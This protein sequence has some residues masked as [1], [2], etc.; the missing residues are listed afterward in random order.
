MIAAIACLRKSCGNAFFNVAAGENLLEDFLNRKHSIVTRMAVMKNLF[1]VNGL[2]LTMFGTILQ[3]QPSNNT[4]QVAAFYYPNWHP[5]QG[6]SADQ[7][8]RG[9]FGEWPV[10]MHA[11]PRFPGHDQ[12]KV[13]AWGFEDEATPAIMTKKIKAAADHGVNVFLFDWYFNAGGPFL[14]QA[15]NKGYLCATNRARIKFALMWANHDCNGHSGAIGRATFDKLVEHAVRDYMT[16]PTYW[17]IEGRPVFSIYQVDQFITGLGGLTA[18]AEALRHFR[19]RARAAG[20]AGVYLNVMVNQ[21]QGRKDLAEVVRVLGIDSAT[22]YCWMHHIFFQHVPAENFVDFENRYF[23]HV[24]HNNY[25]VNY[26]PNVTMGWDPSPRM[27][28]GETIDN[29][30]YPNTSVLTNNTPANFRRTLQRAYAMAL[31]LPPAQRVVTIYAWNEWSEGG[32]LEP[33][34]AHGMA[35]LDAIRDVFGLKA[36]PVLKAGAR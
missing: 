25:S 7:P 28:S 24:T 15:L 12:P 20:L 22:S 31:K 36:P 10:V 32:Y 29:H 5:H 17:K 19:A 33:D 18:A 8:D 13:P 16:Q 1:M 6:K 35:Y 34:R 21:L 30:G 26:W 3:A 11:Y 14:E 23:G 4:P 2:L 27:P 9:N